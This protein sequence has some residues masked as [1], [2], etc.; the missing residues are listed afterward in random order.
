M[1]NTWTIFKRELKNYFNSPIAYIFMML[2]VGIMGFVFFFFFNFFVNDDASM[3]FYFA[4]LPWFFIVFCAA[5]AMRLWSE[6]QKVGT[7][8]LLL[9]MPIRSHEVVLGKYFAGLSILLVTLL[10]TL[11]VPLTLVAMGSPDLGKIFT[12][13]LGAVLAGGLLLGLGAFISAT[14]ENQIVALMVT[15]V[16]AVLLMAMGIEYVV[17]AMNDFSQVFTILLGVLIVGIV[18][19]LIAVNFVGGLLGGLLGGLGGGIAGGLTAYLV[20]IISGGFMAGDFLASFSI[21]DHID[22]LERGVIDLRDV[23]YFASMTTL[24]LLFNYI[25]VENR[26]Y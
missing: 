26:K 21:L 8:E 17:N 12:G 11:T 14:T 19:G 16:A 13:Y 4:A 24:M 22:N 20:W 9:T 18:G 7:L 10:L 15:S 3:R 6:E 2:F 25:A 23:V 5:I 1:A